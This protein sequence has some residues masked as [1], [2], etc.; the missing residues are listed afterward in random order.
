MNIKKEIWKQAK[1]RGLDWVS[2]G[3]GCDYVWRGIGEGKG[4]RT[5]EA[6]VDLVLASSEDLACS[7]DEL[8]ESSTVA[9]YINDPDW[10]NGV[11]IEFP[12]ATA[13]MDFMELP[14][15]CWS[16]FDVQRVYTDKQEQ[17]SKK[18]ET[19]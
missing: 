2:T 10:T 7:P 13:A 9:I 11:F 12:C 17:E 16:A 14:T 15:T 4:G 1:Q 18:E 5:G 3:G 8:G 6:S 19:K